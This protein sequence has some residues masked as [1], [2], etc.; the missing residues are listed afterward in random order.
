LTGRSFRPLLVP[1]DAGR[2]EEGGWLSL[3][4]RRMSF[5]SF[6]EVVMKAKVLSTAIML[7][8]CLPLALLHTAAQNDGRVLV[9][10]IPF[11]F[12]VCRE[13]FPAGKYIVKPVN[14]TNPHILLVGSEDGRSVDMACT[15]DVYSSKAP[16][17][18]K[19]VF[20]RY[21]D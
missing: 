11:N 14:K 8:L 5:Q 9:G 6:V 17:V 4:P 12:T 15:N 16:A 10:N 3:L 7:G 13:E 18:G 2:R 20:H 19:L 1:R 21:G